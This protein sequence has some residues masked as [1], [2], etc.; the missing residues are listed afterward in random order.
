VAQQIAGALQATLSESEKERIETK[1]TEDMAAYNAYL[2]GRHHLNQRN[3]EG[4]EKSIEFFGEAVDR[5]PDFSLAHAGLADTY[6]LLQLWH[7]RPSDE[8]M[9]KA[10]AAARRALAI[11]DNLSEAHTSLAAVKHWYLWD[12]D[13]AEI[14]YRR[15]IQ[16]NPSYATAHHWYAFYLRDV[17]RLEEAAAEILAA[18]RLDPLS[19]IINTNVALIA[20]AHTG[21]F[22]K[23]VDQIQAVLDLDPD[24][25]PAHE[26]LAFVY[27]Q[28]GMV[29]KAVA[30]RLRVYEM[31]GL[32]SHDQVQEAQR[33]SQTSGWTAV[34]QW[35]L[36]Q[37]LELKESTYVDACDIAFQYAKLDR[38][39]EAFEWLDRAY[40]KRTSELTALKIDPTVDNLR[41]DPRFDILLQKIGLK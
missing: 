26:R 35:I 20:Y 9:P 8:A 33:V 10:E 5:D 1:P 22:D 38:K 37:L 41:S 19:R 36:D 24:F 21:Q 39:D 4:F 17:G 32:F 30:M 2:K 18:R 16:L 34:Q 15:A 14:E 23:A 31:T 40:E 3:V 25:M 6:L 27:E 11:D 13:G 29:D 12:W 28:T 7:L